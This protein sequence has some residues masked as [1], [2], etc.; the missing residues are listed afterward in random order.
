MNKHDLRFGSACCPS[1]WML[2]KEGRK[3]NYICI[4]IIIYIYI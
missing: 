1:C 3:A 2:G 4:I